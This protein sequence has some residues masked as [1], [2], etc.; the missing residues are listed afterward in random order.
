MYAKREVTTHNDQ[1][2]VPMSTVSPRHVLVDELAIAQVGRHWHWQARFSLM[3]HGGTIVSYLH[4]RVL[5][6]LYNPVLAVLQPEGADGR[7]ETV[8]KRGIAHSRSKRGE[9]YSP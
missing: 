9:I 4:C 2:E 8:R 3:N 5:S 6:R 1:G 7:Q